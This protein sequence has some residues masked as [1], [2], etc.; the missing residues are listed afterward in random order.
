MDFSSE[1][2]ARD[3]AFTELK[4]INEN[5]TTQIRQKEDQIWSL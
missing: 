3:A 4:V 1:T 2:A 5:P